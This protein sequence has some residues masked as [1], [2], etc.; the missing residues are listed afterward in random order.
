MSTRTN[1]TIAGRITCSTSPS[2]S[3]AFQSEIKRIG[4]PVDY[5]RNIEIYAEGDPAESLYQ[6]ISGTVRSYKLLDD[7]RR[8]IGAF[9]FPGD[10]FGLEAGTEHTFAAEAIVD[11]KLLVIRRNSFT[12]LAAHNNNVAHQLWTLSATEVRRAQDHAT[13]L[14]MNAEERVLGFLHEMAKRSPGAA[15][16]DLPMS[17][18]DIAD[19]LG[20]TVET[21]SR[22]FKQLE[23]SASI[24][25]PTAR[26]IVLRHHAALG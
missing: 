26:H 23:R 12:A 17:R 13:V 18:G 24:A 3:K 2:Q 16:I 25:L 5:E 19:Y 11:S 15:E 1:S 6:V 9:Y 8:Q 20:L 10:I 7:G 4:I 22:T 14:I 21:I